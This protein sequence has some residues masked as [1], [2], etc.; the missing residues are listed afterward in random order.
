MMQRKVRKHAQAAVCKSYTPDKGGKAAG[1]LNTVL[2]VM[3][4]CNAPTKQCSSHV[5]PPLP[6]NNNKPCGIIKE[7]L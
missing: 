3:D 1:C 6:W 7:V 2:S 5:C 4:A